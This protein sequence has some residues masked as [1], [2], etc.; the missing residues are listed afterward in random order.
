MPGCNVT[1]SYLNQRGNISWEYVNICELYF[2]GGSN[3]VRMYIIAIPKKTI[4]KA[5][6]K[7]ACQ[8][9]V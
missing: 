6:P 8:Q 7:H 4:L 1:Y 9:K 3:H 5:N 2:Y